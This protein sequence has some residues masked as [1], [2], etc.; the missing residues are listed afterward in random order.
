MDAGVS[1]TVDTAVT[2]GLIVL[3]IIFF[4]VFGRRDVVTRVSGK[5][6]ANGGGCS[7]V[8]NS[9]SNVRNGGCGGA[10][11]KS[12]LDRITICRENLIRS[13]E[14]EGL[15]KHGTYTEGEPLD[16]QHQIPDVHPIL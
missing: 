11:S 12:Y 6:L 16:E 15:E 10:G 8:R 14:D 4:A 5:Y 9:D 1:S 13:R 7:N 3:P 2:A